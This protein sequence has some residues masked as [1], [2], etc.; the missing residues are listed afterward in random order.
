MDILHCNFTACYDIYTQYLR[1]IQDETMAVEISPQQFRI[2]QEANEQFCNIPTP[3]QPLA[4]PPSCT[5]AFYTKNT[6]S[7]STRS[8]LQ[9]RKTS[10]VSMPSQLAPTV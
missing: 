6:A 2:C 1:I 3:F 4:N 7:I 9:I 5:I 8:S 10:D